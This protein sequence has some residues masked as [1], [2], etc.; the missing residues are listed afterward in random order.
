M[1]DDQDA[2]RLISAYLNHPNRPSMTVFAEAY[3]MTGETFSHWMNGRVRPGAF[4]HLSREDQQKLTA[5]R[6]K[7]NGPNY[8]LP[9]SQINRAKDILRELAHTDEGTAEVVRR[10]G[11]AKSTVDRWA[12]RERV[13]EAFDSL[14][15]EEQSALR[16]R[17]GLT[18]G[19][20]APQPA[21]RL[22]EEHAQGQFGQP[23]PGYGQPQ[24][25]YAEMGY[26]Q[27]KPVY[28]E[29]GYGQP[30]GGQQIPS[31]RETLG[32]EFDPPSV[33]RHPASGPQ[34]GHG[35]GQF[36]QPQPGYAEV[37]YGQPQPGYGQMG[38]GQPQPGYA[39]MG[40]GQPGGGQQLLPLSEALGEEFD[41]PY[42][43]RQPGNNQ[44]WLTGQE[45]SHPQPGR[46]E[47]NASISDALHQF[48]PPSAHG[49]PSAPHPGTG[50]SGPAAPSSAPGHASGAR[51]AR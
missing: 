6:Q 23:Q 29:M 36:E 13:P 50:Y 49:A 7:A 37:G 8:R 9:V 45:P 48:A 3:D 5:W 17:Y 14:S 32:P 16:T 21:H 12:R 4:H 41:P 34:E 33:H 26:G 30:G 19:G 38:S 51:R 46:N 39:E 18:E 47:Q 31:L 1:Q 42:V 24:P 35:Q 10:H 43:H 28:P 25:V 27:P 22:G 20:Q 15:P 44:Q 11:V 40:Y 2:A